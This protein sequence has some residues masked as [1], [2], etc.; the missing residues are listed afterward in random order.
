M[1][2]LFGF[3]EVRI[4]PLFWLF[5]ICYCWAFKFAYF[6]EH[7]MDYQLCKFQLFAMSKFNFTEGGG[8]QPPLSQ[9][10]TGKKKPSAFRVNAVMKRKDSNCVGIISD[11]GEAATA[12]NL[13]EYT[14]QRAILFQCIYL[15]SFLVFCRFT[16]LLYFLDDKFTLVLQTFDY[17]HV[18]SDWCIGVPSKFLSGGGGG[19][20]EL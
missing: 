5:F 3:A 4:L 10:C 17:F 13:S 14:M 6:V 2:N 19:G 16:C 7:N 1:Y 11:Q 8:K 9:C 20:V 18:K 15:L 12:S